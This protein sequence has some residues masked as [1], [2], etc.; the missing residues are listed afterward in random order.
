MINKSRHNGETSAM[1]QFSTMTR[2][3]MNPYFGVPQIHHDRLNIIAKRVQEIKEVVNEQ[4]FQNDND[5]VIPT[6]NKLTR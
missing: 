2:T 1:I 6:I 5:L 4:I 3:S